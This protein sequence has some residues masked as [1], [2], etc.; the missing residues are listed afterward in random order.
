MRRKKFVVIAILVALLALSVLS[1]IITHGAG[2]Q[3]AEAKLLTPIPTV[4][5]S[6]ITPAS[7]NA[8]CG[9]SLYEHCTYEGK[10]E[11]FF[12][13]DP[14]LNDNYIGNNTVSSLIV[15]SGYVVTLYEHTYYGGRSEE[16]IGGINDMCLTDNYIGNN[17]VSSIKVR[18]IGGPSIW[19]DRGEGAIYRVCE[20]IQVCYSVPYPVY[21][22]IWDIT[23]AGSKIIL[24]G[25]DDGT[26]G[27]F[28]AIIEKPTGIETLRIETI[29]YGQVTCT[30]QTWFDVCDAGPLSAWI[31]TD[32]GE[33]S[34]YRIGDSMRLCYDVSR[35]AYVELWKTTS[36]GST[37][38]LYGYDDGRGDCFYATVG[39]PAGVHRYRIDGY[40]CPP[41]YRLA[42]D[43]TWVDVSDPEANRIIVPQDGLCRMIWVDQISNDCS[44]D[45]GLD[46]PQRMLLRSNLFSWEG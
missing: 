1:S 30:A 2:P 8:L 26:G 40:D 9:V 34:T 31:W 33:G 38:M 32:R 25:Y 14:D 45:F 15:C 17:T 5:P 23:P 19:V 35:P 37:L 43:E 3:L 10:E 24:Q 4:T 12:A 41:Q 21:I 18:Q 7:E 42:W 36:D 20:P 16:F 39:P 11:V 6:G 28:S 44:G 46:S 13:D 22:R 29:E 27:C